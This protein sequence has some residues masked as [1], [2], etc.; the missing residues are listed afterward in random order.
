MRHELILVQIVIH[1]LET[2][3]FCRSWE[4]KPSAV[5][6]YTV[7]PT[8]ALKS[9]EKVIWKYWTYDYMYR[10][11]NSRNREEKMSLNNKYPKIRGRKYN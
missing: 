9:A 2:P 11:T 6:F 5:E 7:P 8:G 1:C 3:L 10:D 4:P